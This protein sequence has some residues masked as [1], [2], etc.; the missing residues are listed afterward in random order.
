[1]STLLV[2]RFGAFVLDALA[3]LAL[4]L[5]F[6]IAVTILWD[7][8]N[9]GT[10]ESYRAQIAAWQGHDLLI[11]VV[12][13]VVFG[14]RDFMS[15]RRV[16]TALRLFGLRVFFPFA[17]PSVRLFAS[18]VRAGVFLAAPWFIAQSG[19]GEFLS[20]DWNIRASLTIFLFVVLV[21]PISVAVPSGGRWGLH[22]L[23]VGSRVYILKEKPAAS[24]GLHW[25]GA[26]GRILMK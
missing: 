17:R 8:S 22:D 16:P 2:R 18:I 23:I 15:D 1:M 11:W 24:E 25:R 13:I 20:E 4:V 9:P 14:L 6:F 5:F 3:I 7:F 19:F 21:L 12:L 10:F 26:I